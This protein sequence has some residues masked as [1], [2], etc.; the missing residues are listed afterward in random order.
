MS[1]LADSAM[2]TQIVEAKPQKTVQELVQ[3]NWNKIAAV[4]PRHMTSERVFA[5]AMSS[6]NSTPKLAECSV[7][8]F[9]SCLMKGSSLGL[10]PSNVD[11]RGLYYILP[12]WNSKTR[13]YEA[14]FILGYRGM[15]ELAR[16]AGVKEIYAEA[17]H[18]NDQFSYTLGSNR[19]VTHVPKLDGERGE[20]IGVY[21]VAKWDGGEHLSYM[22]LD[23]IN[24]VMKR[25]KTWNAKEQKITSGPWLTDWEAM[26]KKSV[27]RREHRW[28]PLSPE[29]QEAIASDEL[30]GAEIDH[31]ARLFS[32]PVMSLGNME[33][34]E[35]RVAEPEPDI[36][37]EPEKTAS[38]PAQV[39]A[40][41]TEQTKEIAALAKDNIVF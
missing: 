11:G 32:E 28:L 4:M 26:A 9:L 33:A 14:T 38:A 7:Q 31:T 16:R 10:E 30:S 12:F 3:S 15:I 25:A 39:T 27:I 20:I 1:K 8:S 19:T 35:P 37:P 2:E 13:C 23:E 29:A 36:E 41:P 22:T 17:V 6:Y 21:M 34:L 24:D 5:L 40:S 18:A